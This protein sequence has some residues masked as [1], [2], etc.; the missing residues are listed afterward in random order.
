MSQIVPFRHL[1]RK[2]FEP[3]W[4]NKHILRVEIVMKEELDAEGAA[5]GL[6]DDKDQTLRKTR[7]HLNLTSL[8]VLHAPWLCDCALTATGP[9]LTLMPFCRGRRRVRPP[10]VA[11]PSTTSTASSAT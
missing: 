1:N 7:G 8:T 11:R 5:N 2:L 10:Q 4:N 9:F 3:L 6:G